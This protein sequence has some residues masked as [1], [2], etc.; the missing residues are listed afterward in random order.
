MKTEIELKITLEV[1]DWKIKE[2]KDKIYDFLKELDVI[3]LEME[4]K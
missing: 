4:E 3:S 2:A 1:D